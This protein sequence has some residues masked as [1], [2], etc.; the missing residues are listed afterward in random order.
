MIRALLLALICMPATGF[1]SDLDLGKKAYWK[2]DFSAAA[3]AYRRAVNTS[4]NIPD[5]WFNLGTAEASA[6]RYGHAVHAFEQ[7]LSLKPGDAGAT[8]NLEI[9]RGAILDQ[10]LKSSGA[11]KLVLPGDDDVGTGLLSQT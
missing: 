6:G 3:D 4:G 7:A 2:G 5:L 10:A 8:H 11:E 9:V 1:T